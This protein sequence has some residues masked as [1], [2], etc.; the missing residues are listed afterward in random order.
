[1]KISI[2]RDM[3]QCSLMHISGYSGRHAVSIFILPSAF[4]DAIML[5]LLFDAEERTYVAPKRPLTTLLYHFI[6]LI[7]LYS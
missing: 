6:L 7:S 1:M 4:H 2:F 5:G 3:T